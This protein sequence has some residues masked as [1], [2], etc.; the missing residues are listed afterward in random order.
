MRPRLWQSAVVGLFGVVCALRIGDVGAQTLDQVVETGEAKVA[1]GQASQQR[2]D[3]I[4]DAQQG[5]LIR[6][7]ALLKQIEG[8]EQYNEQLATQVQGQ[9]ALIEQ[10]DASVEQVAQIERQMLPLITRMSDALGDF[11]DLDLPFHETERAE[12][13][14]FVRNSIGKAD[15][16]VAEKFR[17]VIEA[18]Q[19]ENDY[20]RKIDNY[21]DIIELDG[22]PREVDVLRFGRVALAAQTK[23]ANTT[24][25]WDRDAGQW[26]VVDAGDYRNSIRHGIRMAK[27]Q[28]SIE[29]IT[30]PVP[31]PEAAQ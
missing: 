21:Q 6:Y 14:A 27:K 22:Q 3:K 5:K 8:L 11:V 9:L 16:S 23:D 1:E 12:R 18:Y 2:V 19:I 20:G 26:Q 29:M 28:A 31:A 24:A 13:L 7:R 4:V 25:V 15:V 17:Q 30:L 10:F